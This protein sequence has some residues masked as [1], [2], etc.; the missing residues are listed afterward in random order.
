[1]SCQKAIPKSN[2]CRL[3]DGSDEKIRSRVVEMAREVE[4][5]EA[6]AESGVGS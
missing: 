3:L 1:M 2:V 6:G 4:V 5:D